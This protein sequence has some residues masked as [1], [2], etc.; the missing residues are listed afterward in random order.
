[1]WREFTR[2]HSHLKRARAC[3][4]EAAAVSM[5]GEEAAG[6]DARRSQAGTSGERR[7]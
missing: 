6:Q 7:H 4:P 5:G 3:M 2:W 1:M